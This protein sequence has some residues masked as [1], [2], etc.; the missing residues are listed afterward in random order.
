[1][2]LRDNALTGAELTKAAL[3]ALADGDRETAQHDDAV[4][5]AGKREI[6]DAGLW[7]WDR[8]WADANI[9]HLMS[10]TLACFG[11]T[12]AAPRRTSSTAHPY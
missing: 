4:A 9:A 11:A 12:T 7:G 8:R 1:M 10:A 2:T 3:L 5:G 6:P